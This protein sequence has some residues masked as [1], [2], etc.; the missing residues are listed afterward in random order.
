[1]NLGDWLHYFAFDV[2]G[3]IAFSQPFGFLNSGVDVEG[4]IRAIDQS[5]L[6]NGIIGHVPE[7]DFLFRRNPLWKCIPAL[8]T[9]NALIYR[10]TLKTLEE[11]KPF[12]KN[13]VTDSN[14]PLQSLIDCY[15]KD[16]EKF[17]EGDIFAVAHGAM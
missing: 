12:G 7:L 5:Q 9:G 15:L 16:A 1:V 2:L 6:Y 4:S 8:S 14:D 11:K 3:E 13:A 10:M 17:S